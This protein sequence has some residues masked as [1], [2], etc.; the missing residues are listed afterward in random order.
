MLAVTLLEQSMAFSTVITEV[1]AYAVEESGLDSVGGTSRLTCSMG[2]GC[3]DQRHKAESDRAACSQGP[4]VI[5]IC[6]G[7][8][9]FTGLSFSNQ[10]GPDIDL[11][12]L[13]LAADKNVDPV[14]TDFFLKV[15]FT[16]PGNGGSTFDAT[17]TGMLNPGNGNGTVTINFGG[18][19]LI[20]FAGGSFNLTV[21][22][23][24]RQRP[25]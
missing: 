6:S 15:V 14:S 1:R 5:A 4:S 16:D 19:Q 13:A 2:S 9:G 23:L 22:D 20:T 8:L 10:S 25:I 12:T 11:G 24:F 3:D 17:L 18:A 7:G 21:D